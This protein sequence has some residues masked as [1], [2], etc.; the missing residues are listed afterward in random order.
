KV[1]KKSDP[2]IR[3]YM[4]ALT[5]EIEFY[6]RSAY[7]R[8][9]SI[10][11]VFIGGGTPSMLPDDD[12]RDVLAALRDNFD[13]SNLQDMSIEMNLETMTASNLEVCR[14]LGVTRVS[15]GWQ[16]S[17]PRLRKM[18]AL[19]ASEKRL[20][21]NLGHLAR[22]GYPPILD[23]LYAVPTQTMEEWDADL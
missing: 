7:V 12:L 13:L 9:L 19:V 18:L 4:D 23:L 2:A 15:F 22:L 8:G 20:A 17:V 14:D 3:A 16:T 6:G 5:R 1:L 10:E 11:H 21:D